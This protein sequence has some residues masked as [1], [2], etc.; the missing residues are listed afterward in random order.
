M[1][2]NKQLYGVAL[3]KNI[4]FW[5]D[6]LSSL[7]TIRRNCAVCTKRRMYVF[8][9]FLHTFNYFAWNEVEPEVLR[10]E[11]NLEFAVNIFHGYSLSSWIVG[12]QTTPNIIPSWKCSMKAVWFNTFNWWSHWCCHCVLFNFRWPWFTFSLNSILLSPF[13]SFHFNRFTVKTS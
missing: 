5:S 7:A 1:E 8:M 12:L 2:N 4:P 3:H 6:Q 13:C 10:A 9:I 11:L